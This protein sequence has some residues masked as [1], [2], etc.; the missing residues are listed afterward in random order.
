MRH[1]VQSKVFADIM[2]SGGKV[3]GKVASLHYRRKNE[4]K[5]L[6]VG[7][8]ISKKN[9]RKAVRRNYIRRLVY[10]YFQHAEIAGQKAVEIVVRVGPENATWKKRTISK[11]IREELEHLSKKAGIIL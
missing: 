4:Q 3:R 7:I 10:L 5:G 11:T 9:V 8:T 1:I 6:A 2:K